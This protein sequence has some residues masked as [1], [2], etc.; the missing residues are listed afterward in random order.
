MVKVW[1]AK[2]NAFYQ[3]DFTIDAFNKAT[4]YSMD[5][6]TEDFG[7]PILQRFAEAFQGFGF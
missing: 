7:L 4:G 1:K 2:G 6:K 5:E 3:S